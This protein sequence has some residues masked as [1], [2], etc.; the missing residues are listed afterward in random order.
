MVKAL[1]TAAVAHARQAMVFLGELSQ[2]A[3]V[4]YQTQQV[5][6]DED[7]RRGPQGLQNIPRPS[8][9]GKSNKNPKPPRSAAEQ[10]RQQQT[11]QKSIVRWWNKFERPKGAHVDHN[12]RLQPW[13]Y[14]LIQRTVA[15]SMLAT[16]PMGTFLIRLS[17]R[18][19]GYALS[20]CFRGRVRHYKIVISSNVCRILF[21]C[22]TYNEREVEP[23]D[24]FGW[25]NEDC[26][27]LWFITVAS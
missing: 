5:L 7:H 20:F 13:F 14:G 17:D 23:W 25:Q 1:R 15:E 6:Q 24:A 2:Q 26:P 21:F 8:R 27:S 18:F 12:G 16:E 4:L 19:T 9:R 11:T 22:S 10:R 3:K